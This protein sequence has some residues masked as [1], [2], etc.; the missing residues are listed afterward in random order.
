MAGSGDENIAIVIS[1]SAQLEGARAARGELGALSKTAQQVATEVNTNIGAFEAYGKTVDVTSARAVA[2]YRRQG[3]ALAANLSRLGATE[4]ELNRVGA[5]VSKL[6]RAAGA[7]LIVP[8]S[9]QSQQIEGLPGKAR[10]AANAIG[11]LSQAAVSGNG[12]L[13][14]LAAA[15][16]NVAT[17]LASV[18]RS[19]QV[20]AAATGIGAIVTLLSVAYGIYHDFTEQTKRAKEQVADLASETRGLNDA[21]NGNEL[22]QRLEQINHAAEADIR[23]AKELKFHDKERAEIIAGIEARRRALVQLATEENERG[24]TRENA[25]IAQAAA[26]STQER[27]DATVRLYQLEWEDRKRRGVSGADAGYTAH[28][29]E[30]ERAGNEAFEQSKDALGAVVG[31]VNG[32]MEARR[33][34]IEAGYQ[35]ELRGLDQLTVSED[36]RAIILDNINAKRGYALQLLER[37]QRMQRADLMI[38]GYS[39]S[40]SAGDRVHGR[41]VEIEKERLQRIRDYPQLEVEATANAEAKKRALYRETAKQANENLKTM[42]DTL[43]STNDKSLKAVGTFGDTLRRVV[44]GA[45]AAESLVDAAKEGAAAIASLAIGDFRGAALHGAASAEF[46]AAA[47]LGARESLGGGGGSGS[48]GAGS[49]GGSSTFTPRTEAGAGNVTVILQTVDPYSGEKIREVSY[50]LNRNG[51]LNRPIYA[52]PT[53][54][55]VPAGA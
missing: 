7:S 28:I 21:I 53:N 33:R 49:G 48:S 20:A 38:E 17:G 5:A 16:G 12:S 37:E 54:G 52:P 45:K 6:E 50:L 22:G 26:R 35:A 46:G 36:R 11:I 19:A 14:G 32:A 10:T 24:L 9:P 1:T 3:D 29:L 2:A 51:T 47:A 30:L 31:Q 39:L 42:F 23:Q 40:D 8:G 18:A 4:Q 44:I 34:S 55:L 43:R 25:A 27:Y 15:A 13:A 41:E